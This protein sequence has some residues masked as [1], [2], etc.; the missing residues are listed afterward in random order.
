MAASFLLWMG[1]SLGVVKN[2]SG[3][4]IISVLLLVGIGVGA[5]SGRWKEI[6][7]WLK[8]NRRTIF[9]MEAIFLIAFLVWSF[10]RAGNPNIEATEKPMELAFINAILRSPTF[11]PND[12]WLSGYA[13]SY[14]YFGYIHLALLARLTAVSTAVAFN[15]GNSLWFAMSILGTYSLLYN[16]LA[17]RDGRPRL[18]AS[19]LG[20]AFVMIA[21][22]L[23]G[24]LEVLHARHLFWRQGADGTLVS[25]FWKWLDIKSLVDPPIADPAWLPARHWWWWRASR[26][27]ND[28]DLAG[29]HPEVIDEFPFFS[30]LLADNHPHVLA[31]PFV[32]MA[33]AFSFQVFSAG[34]REGLRLGNVTLPDNIR[35]IAVSTGLIILLFFAGSNAIN[36]SAEGEAFSAVLIGAGKG[37][38]LGAALLGV[39]A[40]FLSLIAG[41]VPSILTR[42][43]FWFGAWL[44][45][46][47][48]FLNTWD[49]PI[50]LSVLLA[51]LWWGV[52]S[53]PGAEGWKS[54]LFT[55]LGIAFAGVLLYL[56][57]Y[58][59]FSSQAG[60]ILPNLIFPTKLRQFFVMFGTS[61]VPI[62]VWLVLKAREGWKPREIR[63][64]IGIA[65]AIPLSLVLVSLAFG[66]TLNSFLLSQNPAEQEAAVS[67]LGAGSFEEVVDAAVRRLAIGWTPLVLGGLI[68]IG[69]ILIWRSMKDS[70]ESKRH[71]ER[72]W[73]FIIIL[74]GV[75]A[76]LIMGP[77]FLYLK[78]LF[79]NRM[80][81]VFK[82][83]Y[84]A[85]I[86][87]GIAAA[88]VTT[89]LWPR[90][91]SFQGFLRA[92]VVIPLIMGLFYPIMS[93][94]TKTNGFKPTP[95]FTLDGT[96][97]I[98]QLW[99]EDYAAMQW[100]N[101]KLS[102][103][104][105]AEAV[106]GSY[107]DFGRVSAHTGMP[108]VL[109]WDFHEIQWRGSAEEQG[110]RAQD[111]RML[112]QTTH[113]SEAK[114][115]LDAYAIDYVYVGPFEHIAYQPVNETKFGVYMDLIYQNESVRIF[116]RRGEA[117]E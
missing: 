51:V 62:A 42:T 34:K 26:V 63:T 48:A 77:E 53:E 78:D 95:G 97:Y 25:G 29:N 12:P 56:P 88:Y 74:I 60:G 24:F 7:S 57:W 104:V 43:E 18:A 33:L 54:V 72:P 21:G 113:W 49:F 3:G 66:F 87:W 55:T 103:G 20:P 4:A 1:A 116:A 59:G 84:A 16:L 114:S 52:R 11:P 82:F 15:L 47:L 75:G 8:A 99:P 85:W 101:E 93:T 31:L 40:V 110:S 6:R 67:G 36:A 76:L 32:L 102:E 111:I 37:V 69:G 83:Y 23:E 9:M 92:L 30:F 35:K 79:L 50:Y 89:E 65:V 44:F 39:L 64:L 73:P 96:A 70:A 109:G 90:R 71:R 5:Y 117:S 115:V 10:V 45:G 105:I 107:T 41:A 38:I 81:T 91:W 2:S 61:L 112:Y 106:G 17:K 22:N 108:T 58:P 80:N 46:G 14:Y 27:V 98:D 68:A 86:M 94:W 19:L 28:V 13:I 100:I